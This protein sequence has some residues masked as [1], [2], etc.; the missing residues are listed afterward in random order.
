MESLPGNW[1]Q[2]KKVLNLSW[3]KEDLL[4]EAL[5]HSSYLNEHRYEEKH[6]NERLEFLGDAV[7]ELVSSIY[8]YRQFPDE[9]EGLLTNL[10]AALVNTDNLTQVSRKLGIHKCL[11][12]SKGEGKNISSS[13]SAILADALEAVIGAI[14]LDQG[15]EIASDF[16]VKNIMAR[17]KE[18]LDEK[19]YRDSKSLFQEMAQERFKKTPKYKT[20]DSLGPDHKKIFKVGL[21]LG[22]EQI[23]EGSGKSKQ[24]AEEDAAKNG[25][26]KY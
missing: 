4:K 19:S 15:L 12:L 7:L 5:T 20:L 24:E 25:L 2:L 18:V 14:Y 26:A 1:E 16:I 9:Q 23:A 6:H 11:R 10:R 17:Y 3:K 22:D 8:L 21:Y 13:S